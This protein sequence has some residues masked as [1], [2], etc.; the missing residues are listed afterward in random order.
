MEISYRENPIIELKDFM[1]I[2]ERSTLGQRRPMHDFAAMQTMLDH[3]NVYVGAYDGD[4]LVGLARGMTDFVYTTYL[5]DLAVDVDYQHRG[6]GKELLIRVKKLHPRAKLI[7][8]AAPAA[9]GYYPKIGMQRH[10]HCF[11]IDDVNE[12]R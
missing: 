7:L 3:A 8:L 10:E 12:I 1:A 5:A 2:L 11:F 6:I 4:T 9:Q